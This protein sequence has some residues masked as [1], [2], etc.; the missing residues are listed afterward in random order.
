MKAKFFLLIFCSFFFGFLDSVAI[1]P[2][3]LNLNP[4]EILE[5]FDQSSSFEEREKLWKDLV[6]QDSYEGS[7]YQNYRLSRSILGNV[8]YLNFKKP[9]S[10][11]SFLDLINIES[12]FS[13]RSRLYSLYVHKRDL[14]MGEKNQNKELL[15][16]ILEAMVEIRA[17]KKDVQVEAYKK[18]VQLPDDDSLLETLWKR[19]KPGGENEKWDKENDDQKEVLK[20]FLSER[21]IGGSFD[22]SKLK[23]VMNYLGF[24][25]NDINKRVLWNEVKRYYPR[26][27]NKSYKGKKDDNNLKNFLNEQYLLTGEKPSL[28]FEVLMT[29]YNP[30][31]EQTDSTPFESASG[32][33]VKEG[34]AA[35]SKDLEKR[36]PLGSF[37]ELV[38][39]CEID[40]KG[41]CLGSDSSKV[42][43][44][45]RLKIE[46]R[47]HSRKK[48]QIDIFLM[49]KEDAIKFGRRK[50]LLLSK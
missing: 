32:K 36:F 25:F 44:L 41:N 22:F 4:K 3:S 33:L 35:I 9:E 50:A 40:S 1:N 47:M 38:I 17:V 48:N 30:L 39:V 19:N 27:K 31:P 37:I 43:D 42:G 2:C 13:H 6:G 11:V 28:F 12:S 5:F 49:C 15:D 23:D 26:Y 45:F 29:A 46:D 34:Y 10:V 21:L 14:Y 18:G 24:S 16:R 20:N 7:S 8:E